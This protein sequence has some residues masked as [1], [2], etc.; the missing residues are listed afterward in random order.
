M[1]H[2]I[3]EQ[4]R[5]LKFY[6]GSTDLKVENAARKEFYSTPKAYQTLNSLMYP[7][8]ENEKTRVCREGQKLAPGLLY[9]T[10]EIL[11]VYENIF[12]LMKADKKPEYIHESGCL[13]T[14]R[15]E[16]EITLQLLNAGSTVSLT[17]TSRKPDLG[18]YFRKKD[19]L[20]ILE[21]EI[22]SDVP[23]VDVNAI[24]GSDN[25]FFE[26]QEILLPPF[27]KVKLSSQQLTEKERMY[28]DVNGNPP[29]G[30]YKVQ[31]FK[32]F[33]EC[34][35][36]ENKESLLRKYLFDQYQIENA[37][38]VLE[39]IN[40]CQEIGKEEQEKYIRWKAC[41]QELIKFLVK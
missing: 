30:K 32:E 24:L 34:K 3:A 7:G 39:R 2:S 8:I 28:Q 38:K 36:D 33:Q 11:K 25:Q 15:T 17:S 21:F 16:R 26:Q 27:L 10:T 40:L 19:G 13:T 20:L 35:I 6:Q 31:V 37:V 4:I 29:V 14:Y 12:S 9:N 22:S 18:N 5:S 41:F 1:N 23:Y